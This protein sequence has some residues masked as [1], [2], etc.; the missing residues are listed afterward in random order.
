[1]D[2]MRWAAVLIAGLATA[3]MACSSSDYSKDDFQ[4]DLEEEIDLEPNVANCV[5]EG[6]DD[7][8]IDISKF[9]TDSS[10]EDVLDSD[11]QQKFTEV[12]TTCVMRDSDIDPRDMPDPT[13]LTVPD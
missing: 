7:E 13:D 11:E 2:R 10:I 1:M 4:R 12:I 9:D 6:V 3:G 5:V 8:G